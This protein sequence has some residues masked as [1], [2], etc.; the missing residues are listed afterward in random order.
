M[1]LEGTA[2]PR[3]EDVVAVL[4]PDQVGV[5]RCPEV[6]GELSGE[7]QLH[8]Q[9]LDELA[10]TTDAEL[11]GVRRSQVLGERAVAVVGLGEVVVRGRALELTEVLTEVELRT[12]SALTHEVSDS[13]TASGVE[14]PGATHDL[15]L[16]VRPWVPDHAEA[17][18]PETDVDDLLL[19]V[20]PQDRLVEARTEAE[21][22]VVD[23]LVDVLDE[24]S[25]VVRLGRRVERSGGLNPVPVRQCVR[26]HR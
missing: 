13:E 19:E 6:P 14:S 5:I 24:D 3:A 10:L 8:G 23:G 17:R 22:E 1:L 21:G 2:G 25:E 26:G 20:V 12:G 4:I 15:G 7:V 16:S 11:V 9:V 18:A